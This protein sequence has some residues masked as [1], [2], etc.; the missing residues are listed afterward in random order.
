[1]TESKVFFNIKKNIYKYIPRHFHI[2]LLFIRNY[3]NTQFS[4]LL[5]KNICIILEKTLIFVYSTNLILEKK[6]YFK[7][8]PREK[9][10]NL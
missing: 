1:M 3:L 6:I 10:R 4:F 7:K 5:E 2:L 9:Y 8:T